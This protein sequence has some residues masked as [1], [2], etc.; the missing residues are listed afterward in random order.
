MRLRR[1]DDISQI[2]ILHAKCF[3][4]DDIEPADAHWI[5]WDEGKAVGFCSG[6]CLQKENGSFL[7][8]V[9]VVQGYQGKGLQRRLV[10]AYLAWSKK[11]GHKFSVTYTLFSNWKSI[12]NLLKCGYT[13]YAPACNWAGEGVHY[14][15]RE[16]S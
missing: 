7:S 15:Y 10:R 9:G 4:G 8:R 5:L 2:L 12:V 13:F 11:Q 6:A 1:T 16:L 14:F 3:P